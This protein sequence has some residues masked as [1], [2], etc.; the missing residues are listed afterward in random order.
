LKESLSQPTHCCGWC[1]NGAFSVIQY[2]LGSNRPFNQEASQ[3]FK[4]FEIHSVKRD[5]GLV[6][7]QTN[8]PSQ[9]LIRA[10]W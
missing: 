3:T 10:K 8:R 6:F 4:G 2:R 7:D 1:V 5:A 9:V